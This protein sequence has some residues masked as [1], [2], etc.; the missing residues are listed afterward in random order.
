MQF[1]TGQI[2]EERDQL[3]DK[4]RENNTSNKLNVCKKQIFVCE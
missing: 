1:N 4:Q 3:A 2:K